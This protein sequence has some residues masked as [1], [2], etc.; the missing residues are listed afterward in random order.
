MRSFAHKREI[1]SLRSVIEFRDVG[2]LVKAI[3]DDLVA[4]SL[5]VDAARELIQDPQITPS[6]VFAGIGAAAHAQ[7]ALERR[8][9]LLRSSL[10]DLIGHPLGA[11]LVDELRALREQID[12]LLQGH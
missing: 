4:R 3:D 1:G 10:D 8:C 9:E 7:Q 12:R 5:V 11:T 6:S 2:R